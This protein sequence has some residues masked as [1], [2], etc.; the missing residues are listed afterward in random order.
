MCER[1][2]DGLCY[3]C[4]KKRE[5]DDLALMNTGGNEGKKGKFKAQTHRRAGERSEKGEG[6]GGGEREVMRGAARKKKGQTRGRE[7][8]G[9]ENGK[10]ARKGGKYKRI[11]NTKYSEENTREYREIRAN[12]GLEEGT[13]GGGQNECQN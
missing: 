11:N 12:N 2:T 1:G 10:F 13:E 4:E 9:K 7:I 6:G 3:F 5:T 8:R